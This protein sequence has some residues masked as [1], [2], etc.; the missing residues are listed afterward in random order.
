MGS[1]KYSIA[2]QYTTHFYAN[3]LLA[4]NADLDYTLK[5]KLLY[6]FKAIKKIKIKAQSYGASK[7]C[8]CR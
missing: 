5:S 2:N 3:V 8:K 6:T 1:S 7:Y 4:A